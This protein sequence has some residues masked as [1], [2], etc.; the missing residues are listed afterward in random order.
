MS[1]RR[2]CPLSPFAQYLTD[3]EQEALHEL[4]IEARQSGANEPE[5]KE[6]INRYL[7]EI[8]SPE[9]LSQFEEANAKF[10]R[11]RFSKKL[12]KW[13]HTETDCILHNDTNID[14]NKKKSFKRNRNSV[15]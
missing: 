12:S 2:R 4:I 11:E 3:G 7:K 1:V 8:L 13:Y 6:H 14:K 10:E 15:L 9:K 5:I